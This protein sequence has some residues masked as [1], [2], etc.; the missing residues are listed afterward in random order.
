MCVS[1]KKAPILNRFK[2]RIFFGKEHAVMYV[3]GNKNAPIF[4]RFKV[5][6]FFGR[7]HT[8][9]GAMTETVNARDPGRQGNV[10]SVPCGCGNCYVSKAGRL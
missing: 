2:I 5:R 10:F 3:S 6:N 1:G 8:L 4:N 9:H 7:D